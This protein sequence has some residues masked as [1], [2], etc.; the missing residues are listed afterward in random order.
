MGMLPFSSAPGMTVAQKALPFVTIG[1]TAGLSAERSLV[2]TAS[3]ISLI[4]G[5]ANSTAV[6]DLIDT[7]V[8]PAT[9]S[10]ASV[11]VDQKGR[12]TS[13]VSIANNV[14]G[15][16]S[17]PQVAFWSGTNTITG[18]ADFAFDGSQL[19]LA[20]QGTTGG[21][22]VGTDVQWYRAAANQWATPDNIA[23]TGYVRLGSLTA[24]ANTTSGDL[25]VVRFNLNAP[26]VAFSSGAGAFIR[27]AGNMTDTS[28]TAIPYFFRPTIAPGSNSSSEFRNLYFVGVAGSSTGVTLNT[29]IGALYEWRINQDGAI[30]IVTAQSANPVIIDSLSP[31]T[32]G[33]ITTANG[34]MVTAFMRPSGTSVISV[35]TLNAFRSAVISNAGLT[36]GTLNHFLIQNPTNSTFTTQNGINIEALTR[37]TNNYAI[38]SAAGNLH[39]FG[40][41]TPGANVHTA[42]AIS[43]A[44]W[45]T[46]GLAVRVAAA[47]YTD[48]S[49]AAAG[50]SASAVGS[51]FGITTLA[52]TNAITVT[53]GATVYIAGAAVAGANVTLT[54]GYALWVDAGVS[55]FDGD[56]AIGANAVAD[57]AN[58]YVSGKLSTSGELEIN[59]ALNHDGT[60][61]GFYGTTPTAQSSAYTVTNP[62]ADRAFDVAATTVN[63]MAAV[64][65]TLIADLKLTGIIA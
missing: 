29:I 3:N 32:A 17:S 20:V 39:G 9:Y 25:S 16:G 34:V 23:T 64:L 5:G 42:G 33:T 65:G 11:T 51:S 37:A 4:D 24:P 48:T 43:Q 10:P 8:I 35:T 18:D 61:V 36:A 41:V 12:I 27:A 15:S 26:T 57:S 49:T 46:N 14:T 56:V 31:A 6:I 58:L 50:T 47:T 63:E 44:A 52:G 30:S 22:L 21:I 54:R 45:T 59:G 19:A 40:T 53:D 60:T 55:R 13:A 1:N 28:G 7:A 62:S 38:A 2:G